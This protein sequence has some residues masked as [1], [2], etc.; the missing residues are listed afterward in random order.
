MRVD[1]DVWW[2]DIGSGRLPVLLQAASILWRRWHR[3]VHVAG[4]R[5]PQ[6]AWAALAPAISRWIVV[7]LTGFVV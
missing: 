1:P 5:T 4:R 2:C 6:F 7:G 3:S